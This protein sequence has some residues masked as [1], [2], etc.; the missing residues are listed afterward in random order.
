[1]HNQAA[2]VSEVV[3][4]RVSTTYALLALAVIKTL[5]IWKLVK[6]IWAI[7]T[8]GEKTPDADSAAPKI[9]PA[10]VLV[11]SVCDMTETT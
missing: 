6:R 11:T 10:R 1:V 3:K 8:D 9:A 7:I 5:S 2:L 4:A